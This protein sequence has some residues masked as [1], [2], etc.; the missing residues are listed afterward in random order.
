[1][2]GDMTISLEDRK[3]IDDLIDAALVLA[4]QESSMGNSETVLVLV[5][6]VFNGCSVEDAQQRMVETLESVRN[7]H[8]PG[9]SCFNCGDK[10]WVTKGGVIEDGVLPEAEPCACSE[11]CPWCSE[12]RSLPGNERMH[13]DYPSCRWGFIPKKQQVPE[14]SR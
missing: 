3:A 11:P 13:C 14:E 12:T 6:A 4:L 1:M 8:F 10:L 2:K 5:K 9:V 7:A